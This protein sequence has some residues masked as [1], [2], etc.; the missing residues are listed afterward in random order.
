MRATPAGFM[1][2]PEGT[3]A[4]FIG[5]EILMS[6]SPKTRHQRLVWRLGPALDDAVR[7]A[8]RGE[9]F[10]APFDV[11]L[12][13][14]DVVQ[15]DVLFVSTARSA[16]VQDWIRGAPDLVVEVLSPETRQRDLDVKSELYARNGVAEAWLVD[17]DASTVEV[18][19]AGAVVR[20][21]APDVLAPPLLPGFTL[22]LA[23]LFGP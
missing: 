3:L 23:D 18:R 13:S 5:G 8:R 7:Q 4:E 19:R 10:V 20:L 16:I 12:P 2:L 11:H 21:A 9:V 1:S 22:T 14:G 6:P 15:P 17:P